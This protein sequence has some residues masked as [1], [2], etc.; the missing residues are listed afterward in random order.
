[1]SSLCLFANSRVDALLIA[2]S[3]VGTS[4]TLAGRQ[5]A[6]VTGLQGPHKSSGIGRTHTFS[7]RPMTKYLESGMT[8]KEPTHYTR[9][10]PIVLRY[11]E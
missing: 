1:M 8:A 11:M 7:P 6:S 4:A 3:I 2:L 10:K 9:L 5:S